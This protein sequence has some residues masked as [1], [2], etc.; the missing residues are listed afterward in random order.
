VSLLRYASFTSTSWHEDSPRTFCV[1]LPCPLHPRTPLQDEAGVAI[2]D[3]V[4][5]WPPLPDGRTHA[6]IR[7]TSRTYC[8]RVDLRDDLL[9]HRVNIAVDSEGRLVLAPAITTAS[10]PAAPQRQTP[11]LRTLRVVASNP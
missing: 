4:K 2:G 9:A 5:L 7:I 6:R 8:A 1:T 10:L 11:W 3:L